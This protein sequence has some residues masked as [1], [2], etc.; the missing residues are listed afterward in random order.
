[1]AASAPARSAARPRRNR[2]TPEARRS[3]APPSASPC[4]RTYPA[5][6]SPVHHQTKIPP[7]PAP[8]PSCPRRSVPEIGTT[9]SVGSDRSAP[10]GYAESR[11]PRFPAPL[12]APP[13][14]R[15]SAL[16]YAP[17]SGLHLP[18]AAPR[19]FRST[20]S[21]FSRFLLRR[22]LPSAS[23]GLFAARP[24]CSAQPGAL[25]PPQ[26]A[27]RNGFP[28]PSRDPQR[29]RSAVLPSSADQSLL[30]AC[31]CAQSHLSPSASGLSARSIARAACSVP[32]PL[33]SRA[34]AN[35]HPF[36]CAAPAARSPAA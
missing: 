13:R 32:F 22:L 31:V 26:L 18:A 17:A 6:R 3:S 14:A 19:E 34:R 9:Q 4:I 21:R 7:P 2:C 15:A 5:A 10:N 8:V 20:C 27:C 16:P 33:V 29:V 24:A 35:A 11:S 36:P 25:F 30:S 1:M 28:P 23:G 12:P